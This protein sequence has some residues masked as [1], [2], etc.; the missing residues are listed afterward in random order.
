MVGITHK[1]VAT[2]A[3]QAGKEVNKGEWND[4]HDI[5]NEGIPQAKIVGEGKIQKA[6]DMDDS[7]IGDGKAIVYNV[8]AGKHQYIAK[9]HGDSWHTETYEKTSH[10]GMASGYCDLDAAILVPLAR[11]PATLTGK[12]AD[13]VDTYHAASLE[14]TANKGVASGYCELD[15][16]VLVPLARIPATLTGKDADTVDTYHAVAL[17]KVANKAVASGYCDLDGSVLVP[18]ARIP[19]TLTGKD[20]DTLDTL[21]AASFELLSHKDAAS[22]YAGLSAASKLAPGE[23]PTSVV[24]I[25]LTFSIPDALTTGQKKQRLLAP[26]AITLTKVRLVVDTAPTGANLIIDVHTGTGAGTTIFTTQGNRP[27]IVAGSKT[28]VSV[29]PD[30][31]AL[32]EGDELSVYVDQI[33]SIIAGSDLTIELIGIQAVAFS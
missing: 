19:A 7:G 18:L 26:C 23:M 16:A 3:D 12:D 31:T 27:T 22:G 5:G 4:E 8:A 15:A 11:I 1:K 29:A 6:S 33:G 2:K 14:K 20:A 21:H 10:K 13:T 17:E 9:E 30:V 25:A 24:T 28:G 32:A